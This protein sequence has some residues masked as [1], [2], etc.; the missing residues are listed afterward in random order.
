MSIAGGK[1]FD[2][3]ES[4]MVEP[5]TGGTYDH[6]MRFDPESVVGLQGQAILSDKLRAT[7]QL[8]AKGYNDFNTEMEWAYA[9]YALTDEFTVNAGRFRL[10]LFYYSDFLDVGFAYHWI[11]PPVEVYR[12]WTAALEGANVYYTG[13][14]ND[15][16][17]ESYIWYGN[18]DVGS[19]ASAEYDLA[20]EP[21]ID[22]LK[23]QGMNIQFTYDWASVRFLY[24]TADIEFNFSDNAPPF[25]PNEKNR[26]VVFKAVS[27][28]ADYENVVW[29]S[30]YT[31]SVLTGLTDDDDYL[32]K[33]W[34]AS[35]GYQIGSF[36]PHLT[37]AVINSDSSSANLKFDQKT[38]TIG[39][40]WYFDSSAVW[41]LEFSKSEKD[42]D[43]GD[44][45][46]A[47]LISTALD[48]VF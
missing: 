20:L 32:T 19:V 10:P 11:R 24:N 14:W 6:D 36:L 33:N 21:Y 29:R 12:I 16:Q 2:E 41:K 5:I 22:V 47:K 35:I 18:I 44:T 42:F 26:P 3:D 8:V 27:F 1:T 37:H 43:S 17:I 45:G 25:L 39:L 46:D 34:Y 9:S 48:I 30:E 23:N 38:S 4:Y 13:M 40:A 15:I 31:H 28:M 7:I